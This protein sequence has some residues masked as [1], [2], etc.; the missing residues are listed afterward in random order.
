MGVGRFT[1]R[2]VV[3]KSVAAH[4]LLIEQFCDLSEINRCSALCPSRRLQLVQLHLRSLLEALLNSLE[5]LVH[6][7]DVLCVDGYH[8]VLADVVQL[9]LS[10]HLELQGIHDCV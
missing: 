1:I 4:C 10:F 6:V 3:I 7:L 9:Q 2:L 5:L 8:L